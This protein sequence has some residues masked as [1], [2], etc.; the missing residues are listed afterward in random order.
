MYR[1]VSA[2]GASDNIQQQFS[3]IFCGHLYRVAPRA[4]VNQR[5][6]YDAVDVGVFYVQSSQ[7]F[8]DAQRSVQFI[9]V[10]TESV[11]TALNTKV[12]CR[13]VPEHLQLRVC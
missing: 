3:G 1:F 5:S 2:F 6:G 10:G 12:V 7:R 13:P 11:K 4:G 8:G 9:Y